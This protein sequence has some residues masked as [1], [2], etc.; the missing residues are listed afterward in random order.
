MNNQEQSNYNGDYRFHQ[1]PSYPQLP[2][3]LQQQ[4]LTIINPAVS[5]GLREAQHLG[6]QHAL[7]EAVAIGYLMGRG[8]GYHTAWRMV[9]SWWRPHGTP[10]PTPY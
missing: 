8:Y 7:T 4:T 9:E 2:T 5:H 10:L 6:F 3:N 1:Q